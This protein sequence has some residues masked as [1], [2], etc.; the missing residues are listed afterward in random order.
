MRERGGAS[1]GDL[2]GVP[3]LSEM[4][5][6]LAVKVRKEH[7]SELFVFAARA[8]Q[9][10]AGPFGC[11]NVTALDDGAD[12]EMDVVLQPGCSCPIIVDRL[13]PTMAGANGLCLYWASR[14]KRPAARSGSRVSH[15]F[16]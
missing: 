4:A 16:L 13:T 10:F 9:I 8:V 6:L 14:V 5:D 7:A 3:V 15:A 11:E 2:A 12:G 1:S